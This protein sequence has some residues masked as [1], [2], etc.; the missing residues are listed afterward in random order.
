VIGIGDQLDQTLAAQH[1]DGAKA[2]DQW[3]K[4]MTASLTKA[5]LETAYQVLRRIRR[6]LSDRSVAAV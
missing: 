5:E 3:I 2:R 6:E 4:R 1:V